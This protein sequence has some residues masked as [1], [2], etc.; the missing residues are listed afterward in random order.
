MQQKKTS[1]EWFSELSA[2]K[3]L[4]IISPDGWDRE[5]FDQSWFFEKITKDEYMDR[6][7]NSVCAYNKEEEKQYDQKNNGKRKRK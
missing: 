6:L 7:F 4:C 1:E 2:P 5:H 3:G